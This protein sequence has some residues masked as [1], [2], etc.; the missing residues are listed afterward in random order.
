MSSPES[1]VIFYSLNGNT[2]RLAGLIASAARAEVIELAPVMKQPAERSLEHIWSSTTV[3]VPE[4]PVLRSMERDLAPFDLLYIGTPVW[5][6]GAAPPLRT[7][8]KGREFFRRNFALFAGYSGR[9]G[10]VFQDLRGYLTGGEV[11]GEIGFR[12][13]LEQDQSDLEERIDRWVRE[14]EKQLAG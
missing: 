10:K 12:E 5:A 1:A 2:R 6:G 4:E 13:P 14:I 11:L 7:F 3:T 8:L 9:T